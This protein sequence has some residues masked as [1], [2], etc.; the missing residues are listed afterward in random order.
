MLWVSG[1]VVASFRL[2][3][4]CKGLLVSSSPAS[5]YSRCGRWVGA[6]GSFF[7]VYVFSLCYKVSTCGRQVLDFPSCSVYLC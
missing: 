3:W 2:C 5:G 7:S 4:L 1:C 6:E